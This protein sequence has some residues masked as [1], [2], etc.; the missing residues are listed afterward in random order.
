M[1]GR[2]SLRAQQALEELTAVE[3]PTE[4][5]LYGTLVDDAQVHGVLARLQDLGLRVVSMQQCTSATTRRPPVREEL[6]DQ[7]SRASSAAMI[8]ARRLFTSSLR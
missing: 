6:S 1:A 2:L 7:R 4:T 8:A 3:V 5:V